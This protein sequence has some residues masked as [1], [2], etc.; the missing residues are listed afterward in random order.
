MSTVRTNNIKK[1]DRVIMKSGWK[2]TIED[3]KSGNARLATVYG[4]HTET[5]SV[6][7]WDI[8]FLIKNGVKYPIE[9]LPSQENQM[10]DTQVL[11]GAY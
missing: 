8:A 10:H 6:Y 5:G 3:N 1:G 4:I 2:A 9:L 7:A 11:L